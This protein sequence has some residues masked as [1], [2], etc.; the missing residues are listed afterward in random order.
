MPTAQIS[1]LGEP[2]LQECR[3]FSELCGARPGADHGVG[4]QVELAVD[5]LM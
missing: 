3:C 1:D 2:T 5:G 4:R